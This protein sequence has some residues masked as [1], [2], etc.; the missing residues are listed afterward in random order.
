M[1]DGQARRRRGRVVAVALGAA[2]CVVLGLW[3]A[4]LLAHAREDRPLPEFASLARRPDPALGGTV[5]Y[6]DAKTRCVRIVAAAGRPSRD[7]W[8]L[9]EEGPADWAKVGK[10]V[11]PQLVWRPD[12]RLEITMFRM[13]IGKSP[14]SAPPLVP[15]WQK[16]VDV[17][18]GAVEDVPAAAVPSRPNRS[19]QPRTNPDGERIRWTTDAANGK[20]RVTLTSGARTRTVLDVQGPG[21]YTYQFGP[22]FW[23]PN[24]QWIAAT[25]DGRILV[26]TP[27]EPSRTRVLVTDSG[28][29]AGGGTAGP[30]FAVTA[31]DLLSP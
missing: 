4:I 23:A 26:I 16:V 29:G 12:G 9:P 2:A 6:F 14:R 25:D 28:G 11:G 13:A 18:I 5:A 22:V 1:T 20:A 27:T 19:T 8:C 31:D 15:G 17:R 24:W 3:V 7:V 30:T 21:E 10:P